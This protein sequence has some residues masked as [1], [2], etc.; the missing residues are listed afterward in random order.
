MNLSRTKYLQLGRPKSYEVP[1]D[2]DGFQV[3]AIR[4]VASKPLG[5]RLVDV[6]NS[7]IAGASVIAYYDNWLC[8]WAKT[9]DDGRFRIPKMPVKIRTDE[10]NYRV[11]LRDDETRFMHDGGV[12]IVQASPL[13]LRVKP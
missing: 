3:P 2:S 10:A 8:S 9:D 11:V 6:A 13:T 1:A 4:V 5:G 12:S 7:P